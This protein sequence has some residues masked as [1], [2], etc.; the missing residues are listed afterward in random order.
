M[1]MDEFVGEEI[2]SPKSLMAKVQPNC[3]YFGCVIAKTKLAD[4]T[5]YETLIYY[6]VATRSIAKSKSPLNGEEQK[7]VREKVEEKVHKAHK[8]RYQRKAWRRNSGQ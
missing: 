5:S 2:I 4:E 3:D 1:V 8:K 6:M 7:N